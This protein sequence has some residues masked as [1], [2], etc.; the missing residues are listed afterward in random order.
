MPF[1]KATKKESKLRLALIGSSGSGKTYSALSIATGLGG[2]I[3]VVDTERGSASKYADKFNFDVLE[4]DSFSP[5]KYVEAISAAAQ[6]GYQ[7]LIIDSL[8][9]A[10]SGKDGA[11]EMVDRAAKKS[12]SGNT[13][14]AWRDVTPKHNEMVD[15]IVQAPLHVIATMRAKT[16]Y[17]ME[18]NDRGKQVPRKIGLAPIQRDGLEYE[19]DVVAMMTADNEMIVEKT[20]CEAMAGQVYAKPNGQVSE[21]LNRWLSGE[22]PKPMSDDD[23]VAVSKLDTLFGES[24]KG[25]TSTT[26]AWTEA[27]P[28]W[29]DA[30]AAANQ[31]AAKRGIKEIP[32]GGYASPLAGV[33]A[34]GKLI[35]RLVAY[36]IQSS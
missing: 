30:C 27:K 12:Q 9:H 34:L 16:E 19:F 26:E 7:I 13:Y 4:L 21:V 14:T 25:K 18:T 8:S 35:G 22:K 28:K 3:A 6:A 20:R 36:D 33:D 11:L 31:Q 2:K 24:I 29:V 17:V 15:A 32:T 1:V 10:W 23:K 5:E